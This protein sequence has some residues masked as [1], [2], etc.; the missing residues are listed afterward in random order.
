MPMSSCI[1][2]IYLPFSQKIFSKTPLH[3]MDTILKKGGMATSP[4]IRA[5]PN[6]T[7]PN[8]ISGCNPEVQ[9]HREE[10][11][12]F[13]KTGGETLCWNI[14][15]KETLLEWLEERDAAG[16]PGGDRHAEEITSAGKNL[17]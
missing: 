11:E 12:L 14:W 13:S 10:E 3:T 17:G 6:I 5:H 7:P 8:R 9:Y 1:V 16:M 2:H 15:R 4:S